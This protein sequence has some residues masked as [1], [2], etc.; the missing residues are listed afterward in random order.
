MKY[1]VIIPVYNVGEYLHR[2]I[3]SVMKQD[4]DCIEVILVDDGSTDGSGQICDDYVQKHKNIKVI[5][6]TNQGLAA[7][8]NVGLRIAT[9]EWI[10]FLDSDDYWADG[11]LGTIHNAIEKYPSDLYKFNYAKVYESPRIIKKAQII[12]N[13]L[14][15]IS[16]E[17]NK[18]SFYTDKLI[19]YSISWEVVTGVYKK[20]IIEKNELYF[21]D[22]E[23]IYALDLLFSMEYILYSKSV[24]L[25]CNF[26]YMYYTREG[27]LS[28]SVKDNTVLPRL[29]NLLDEFWDKVKHFKLLKKNY[30]KIYFLMINFHV[31]HNLRE[32][33]I[34]I[35]QKQIKDLNMNSRFRK[36]DKLIKRD[37]KLRNLIVS[38]REW[39]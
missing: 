31:I 1:S 8:R 39:L 5:H 4:N 23:E 12:E 28:L 21:K 3:D 10:M 27:S 14:L 26:F 18:L 9:G 24:Y 7:A 2:C 15:D 13:E 17:Y 16:S 36:Y 32:T 38:G 35:I 19:T 6:Q 22:R 34:A 11:L 30:Y 33:N 25:I 37:S 20:S 29:Y